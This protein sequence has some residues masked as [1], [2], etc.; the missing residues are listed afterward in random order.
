[1]SQWQLVL[2]SQVPQWFINGVQ[3]Y[4]PNSSV[5]YGAQLLWQRWAKLIYKYFIEL[6]LRFAHPTFTNSQ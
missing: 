5:K 1:M 3:S 4:T 6:R 2:T